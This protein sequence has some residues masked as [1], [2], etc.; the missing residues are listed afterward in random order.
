MTEDSRTSRLL[1]L[2]L[3]LLCCLAALAAWH[4]G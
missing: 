3:A 4:R 2:A 1:T